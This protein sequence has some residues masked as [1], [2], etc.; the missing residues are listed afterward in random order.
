MKTR[1]QKLLLEAQNKKSVLD[2]EF[3]ETGAF[4]TQLMSNSLA[5][6]IDDL[7][8]QISALENQPS[9]EFG[10]LRLRSQQLNAGSIPLG[11]LA[12]ISNELRLMLGHAALRLTQGG[13]SKKRVPSEL[14]ADLDLRLTSVL[15]GSTRL[16]ITTASERDM[17]GDG[18]SKN[19][20]ERVFA[21]LNSQ[22]VGE[23]FLQS[24]TDLGPTSAKHLRDLLHLMRTHQTE[25][26]FSWSYRG[27]RV[28][29]WQG[30][31]KN[32][33]AVETALDLT[34]LSSSNEVS[35]EGV[36]ELLSKRERIQLACDGRSIRILF[37]KR[38]LQSV[39]ELHLNQKVKLRCSVTETANPL[40]GESST[41]FELLEI[42]Q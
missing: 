25:L 37:P 32:I 39:S 36:V 33:E 34:K 27:E 31:T 4:S 15:Q 22:G 30:L 35:L 8:Q 29:E 38:M 42:M 16:L 1:L 3:S 17:F 18:I 2:A 41:F 21:V 20:L 24:V 26:D 12:N 40:T 10:E 5:S 13:L 6:H 7:R 28:K 14:Y 19:A 11:M 9:I 23:N